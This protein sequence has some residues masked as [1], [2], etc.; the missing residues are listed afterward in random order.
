MVLITTEYTKLDKENQIVE[1]TYFVDNQVVVKLIFDYNKDTTE[2]NGN[3]YD[4][5]GWKHT[6]E[7][8]NKYENYIQIQKWFAKEILN[9]I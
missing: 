4:L 5:I 6:E 8:K 2:I 3:L 1:L 9:K 7:D